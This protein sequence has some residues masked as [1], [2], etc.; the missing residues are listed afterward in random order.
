MRIDSGVA[1]AFGAALLYNL[2]TVVQ[3]SQAQREQASGV[4]L[5]V[6]LFARPVWLLGVG[7]QMAG[8]GLHILALTRAP[9]TIVQP[10][11]AA[12]IVFLVVLAAL[13][14]DERPGQ[15]EFAGIAATMGG[16]VLLLSGAGEPAMM[17]PVTARGF[18]AT[19][20]AAVAFISVLRFLSARARLVRTSQAAVLLG[21]AVG[22]AQGMSDALNRLM[23]AWLSPGAGWT[24]SNPMGVAALVGLFTFG[25]AGF[26]LSQ[27]AFRFYRANTVAPTMQTAQ[28]IVPVAIA[29][30]LYGQ[31]LPSGTVG[32]VIW[33]TAFALIVLGVIVLSSSEPVAATLGDDP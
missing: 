7:C 18:A 23:G 26:V 10:I 29:V 22:L 25:A 4:R 21:L 33:S 5:V 13:I 27:D 30:T 6:R 28:L 20:V 19:I 9:V 31:T 14:L 16:V 2:A 17:L 11:I 1:A 24:P 12:G 3:K 32:S 15:R 8:L